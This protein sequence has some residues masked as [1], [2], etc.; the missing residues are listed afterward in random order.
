MITDTR[1]DGLEEEGSEDERLLPLVYAKQ[2]QMDEVIHRVHI[3]E[4]E[5]KRK[6]GEMKRK[7]DRLEEEKIHMEEKPHRTIKEANSELRTYFDE[8]MREQDER[9]RRMEEAHEEEIKAIVEKQVHEEELAPRGSLQSSIL[10]RVASTLAL[11]DKYAGC[12]DED[13]FSLMMVSK[14]YSRS[15]VLGWVSSKVFVTCN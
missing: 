15:W 5:M 13:T 14:I 6:L 10:G 12:L 3:L 8:K 1:T 7:I 4:E 11:N 9:F 2:T